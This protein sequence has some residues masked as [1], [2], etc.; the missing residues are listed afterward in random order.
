[1]SRISVRHNLVVRLTHW[2]NTLAFLGLIVSGTAILL[3]HPRLYWGETGAYGSPA[4]LELPLPLNTD[5]SGWGRSLHFLAAWLCVLN[6][7]AYVVCGILSR[8][9]GK[10]QAMKYSAAQRIAYLTVVFVLFPLMIV[11][12]LAMSPAV[13]AALP[14]IGSLFGGHQSS[15]TIHF[16]VTDIL[17]LFVI[18][19]V[20]MV[21]LSGFGSG[22]RGMILAQKVLVS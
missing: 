17:V 2:I 9:F 5:Q 15:R 7:I 12:G 3:A 4:L 22:M 21:V 1:M 11:T 16:F 6:G 8:H 14:F 13:T 18:G 10:E 20:A 19:H